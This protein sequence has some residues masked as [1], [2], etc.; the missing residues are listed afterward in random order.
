MAIYHLSV[1]PLSRS[2]GRSAVA[3]VAY[4]AG[5]CLT[6]ERDGVT[7]DYSRRS[8]VEHSE[9]LAP[10]TAPDWMKD[11]GRLWNGV[12]AIEKRKDAR[13]AR[14]VE[15]SLPRELTR[16]Q[17]I[18]SLR[19]FIREEFTS[20]GM[21][22]DFAVHVPLATDGL[23]QPHAHILLTTRELGP[24]GFGQKVRAWDRTEALEEWREA[25]GRHAN[26]ALEAAGQEARIDH[27][28]LKAQHATAVEIANDT[29]RPEPERR[30]AEVKAIELD[31]DPQP[32]L[33]PTAAALERRGVPSFRGDEVRA[34]LERNSLRQQLAEIGQKVAELGKVI[35]DKARDTWNKLDLSG[36][37][38]ALAQA[39]WSA[40]RLDSRALD[41]PAPPLPAL[42]PVTQR[43]TPLSRSLADLERTSFELESDQARGLVSLSLTEE[44]QRQAGDQVAKE[45]RGLVKTDPRKAWETAKHLE[46]LPKVPFDV[47]ELKIELGKQISKE[48]GPE[49]SHRL[50]R[51]IT[52]EIEK[53][54]QR[55]IVRGISM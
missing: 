31:R 11:R 50:G 29:G 48:L 20:R 39:K 1:K 52:Q 2:G 15:V 43:E 18:D 51:Q 41:A 49:M 30:L 10:E 55:Q 46:T 16:E 47:R 9:I 4:R 5:E 32:K 34:V 45:L 23:E 36:T 42:M 53:I 25:W 17:Q 38:K 3:S 37:K 6:N 14:E 8:G 28:S 13:L 19:G 27:R 35:G 12:E 33:G 40:L 24:E 7:H 26:R 44:R 22:A 21:V 54:M